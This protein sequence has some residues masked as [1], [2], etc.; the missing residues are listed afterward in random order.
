MARINESNIT[1]EDKERHSVH[2]EVR[3]TY[4][5]FED[6]GKK[7]FQIDTY[8]KP[9]RQQ[10]E[11]LSQSLQFDQDTAKYLIKLLIDSMM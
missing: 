4:T 5:F 10:P 9:T 11:K 6:N 7:Y 8:G 2:P 1:H 3:A